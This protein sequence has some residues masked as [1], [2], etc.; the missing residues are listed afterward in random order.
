[1]SS[2]HFKLMIIKNSVIEEEIIIKIDSPSDYKRKYP[3]L[4]VT[5]Y[6]GVFGRKTL[7][8]KFTTGW[9]TDIR[10]NIHNQD[11]PILERMLY[12]TDNLYFFCPSGTMKVNIHSYNPAST[13]LYNYTQISLKM[14]VIEE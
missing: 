6:S 11:I 3:E 12:E 1:M 7:T 2:K 9:F 4:E 5:T 14:G 10:G 8:D 13:D